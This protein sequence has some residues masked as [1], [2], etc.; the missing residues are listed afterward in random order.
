MVWSFCYLALRCLLQL[1]LLRPRSKEFKELE[2]VVLRHELAVL[3]RQVGRAELTTA[4]RTLLAAASRL[5]PRTRWR[6]FMVTPT[7][8]LR[9][10]RRLVARRWTYERRSGRPPIEDGIR[11]L[12]LR[13]ARENPR[14]GYQRIAG[15][16]NGLGLRV[17]ATTVRKILHE[18]GLGPAGSRSGLSWRAF[19][20]QQAQS[21]LAVDFFAVETI[22]LQRLYVLFFIELGSRR[23]HLAGC[24]ANPDG[25]WV[26]Q[27]ARQFAW[28]LQEH[29]SRLRFL[30]RDRDSKFTRDFDAVFA[31]EGVRIIKTPVRAP[32]AN[33]IAERFVGT[34]RVECLDWLLIVNRR[35][36]ERVL[37]VYVDHYNSHRPHR[38][39]ELTPPHPTTSNIGSVDVADAGVQRRDRLGGLIHEYSIAA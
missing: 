7:T 24:S 16:I 33:A 18:A 28:T 9:W 17:S 26:T 36:L 23:V 21:M 2:I 8:L 12:V 1:A 34:V 6:C 15:E 32:K 38:S 14:W 31:S 4:D 22:S 27:Q 5:L 30:I 3:L 39:R 35:H 10:H 11:A 37:G 13:L 19:L 20:R 29:P 25:A